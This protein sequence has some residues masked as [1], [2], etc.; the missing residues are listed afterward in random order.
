MRIDVLQVPDG[1]V[2]AREVQILGPGGKFHLR[3]NGQVAYR[4]PD[5]G[6]EQPAGRSIE[7][8][9]AAVEAWNAYCDDVIDATTD[10]D[11]LGIVALLQMR[12]SELDL[13]PDAEVG[14]WTLVLTQ[15]QDG[16]G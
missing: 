8:F 1:N 12:L 9:V 16:L 14:Y 13:L 7:V 10:Q 5:G 2:V 3:L 11:E 4:P 6:K 15:A